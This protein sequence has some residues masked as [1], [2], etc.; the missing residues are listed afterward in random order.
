LKLM[1]RLLRLPVFVSTMIT[2]PQPGLVH[3]ANGGTLVFFQHL[4]AQPLL[5][6]RLKTMVT[7][8]RF[9]WVVFDE[10]VPCPC[11]FLPLPLD[12]SG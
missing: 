6:M 7:R 9:D 2:F 5:W 4:L 8:R 12:L 11:Q 1:S 10:S 3:Q